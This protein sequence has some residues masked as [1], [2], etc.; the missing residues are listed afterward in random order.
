M[1][2]T[3][4]DVTRITESYYD[5]EDADLFYHRVWGGED[6]HVG[7]YQSPAEGIAQA[8]RRTV[9]RMASY[10]SWPG[11]RTRVL[12]LGSGY[13]GAAR[14]L[15]ARFGCNVTCLNLSDVENERNRALSWEQGLAD[16][17]EVVH[18]SFE[19]IPFPAERF[20]VIWSQDAILHSG[21]R[22]RVLE[23][24]VR[25]LG[26]GGQMIFT[27]PMQAD[28]VPDPGALQPIYDRIH[29]DSLASLAFYRENLARLG[30]EERRVEVL[31]PQ[32][33]THYTRVRETLLAQ[34][35]ELVGEISKDYVDRMLG[36]LEKWVDGARSG[37]M[38]WGI[39]YFTKE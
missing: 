13:G 3:D 37:L 19:N 29:L 21:D 14:F 1:T 7:L 39:L 31:T 33:A 6:I 9:E 18:G 30:L 8:S 26:P 23:E 15:A 28:H 11:P 38:T 32:M 2:H 17:I 5:S 16:R 10:L 20:D 36:G 12:D 4:G 35:D 34:Y 24:A 27:D 22:V 25:V